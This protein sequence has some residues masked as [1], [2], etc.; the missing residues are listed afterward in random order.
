MEALMFLSEKRD[1]KKKGRM[2]YNGKETRKWL[3]REDSASP[4]AAHEAIMCTATVNAKEERDVM[5]A[6]LPNAFIQ[7]PMPEVKD[8]EDRVMMKITGVLVDML[9]QIDPEKYGPFVVYEKNRKVLY[10]QVLRAIYGMLQSSLLWYQKLRRDLEQVD[11]V[12]NPYDPCVANRERDGKQHTVVFHVDDLK[13]SHVNS[14]V[15]DEF[16]AW[17][18][19]KYGADGKVKV[20]R[21][22]VHDYLGMTFDYS[23]KGKVIID[24]IPYVED[25]LDEFPKNF[26]AN[27]VAATAAADSLFA[28][29]HGKKLSPERSD[30]FHRIV[31]KGL[32]VCKRARPDIQPTIAGLCTRVKEPDESDWSKLV[33]LM[34]YLNGTKKKKLTLS[35]DNLRVIKW[36]VDASFAVHPDFKSHT[37]AA[38]TFGKGAVINISRKQKLNTKSSTDA[39]LVGANDA[40]VMILWTKLFMEHQGYNIE[41]NIL[42]QD[43]KS[44]ILLETNGRKS[45]GK[46]SR[47]L[48]VRYF[49]LTDQV[50]RGNLSIEYCPTD[51]MWGDFHSKPLQGEKFRR[52]VAAIMGEE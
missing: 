12:F 28:K 51:E 52:F 19:K 6:D 34:K 40:S 23:K 36:Y 9:V 13:S 24:M 49:F 25:M 29:G 42:Y 10:V 43:N 8:D 50:E 7:T 38:M 47:A 27:E 3:T 39:E 26:Q 37:G 21:G 5:T 15:N 31:A 1:G 30:L 16:A 48:N 4:T 22:K 46:R 11:F 32:F 35:A 17:L 2:V 33:R 18:V 44:A 41:K 20:H 45:A 14:K